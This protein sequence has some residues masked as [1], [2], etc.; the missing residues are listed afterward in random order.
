MCSMV[1]TTA[2]M[3]LDIYTYEYMCI[4]EYINVFVLQEQSLRLGSARKRLLV[5]MPL[6]VVLI[7]LLLSMQSG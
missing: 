2:S 7:S 5:S 1:Q 4:C 6:V 3:Y